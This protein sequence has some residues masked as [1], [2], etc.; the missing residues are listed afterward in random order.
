MQ[1]SNPSS[2][3]PARPIDRRAVVGRHDVVLTELD[4]AAPLTVGNGDFAV[5]V[6]VTGLQSLPGAYPV[7]PRE[8]SG[9][10]GTLLG[11]QSTWGWHS[12][13]E[14]ARYSWRDA[15]TAYDAPHGSVPYVD[16][17]GGHHDGESDRDRLLRGNPH[18]LDLGRIG[19]LL[20][21]K[22]LHDADVRTV[23]QQL[24]LL[25]GSIHSLVEI[26]GIPVEVETLCDPHCDL[27]A[28]RIRSAGLGNRLAV[29]LAF[30]YGS[31][32]WHN[33]QD[34]TAP[35]RHRTTCTP[36]GQGDWVLARELDATT[37]QA[38]LRADE[39]H[40]ERGQDGRP[41]D[42][43]GEHARPESGARLDAAG[44]HEFRLTA[45]GPVAEIVV[46]FSPGASA[47]TQPLPDVETVRRRSTA[48]W[49]T[50]WDSG[51]A[52]DLGDVDDPRAHELER[53]VVLSQYLTAVNCSGRMPP[54]ETGLV[55]N[56]W[57]GKSHLEM[58]WWHAAHF[59][60]WGRPE[61]LHRSM[62]WYRSILPRAR[63]MA[64]L[65]GYDGARWPKQVGPE[66]E[67]TPSGIGPFLIWQQPHPIYLA[68]LLRRAGGVPD[69]L[70]EL[71][72]IV[73]ETADFMASYPERTERGYELPSP[74][75]PAQE[76]Y[77]DVRRAVRNPAFELVYWHWALDVACAWNARL[78]VEVPRAWIEVR[79]GII[80]PVVRDGLYPAIEGDPWTIYED[81]PSMLC[82]LG[83]L[84]E[85]SRVDPHVMRATLQDVLARWDLGSTW[86][87][88]Y[89]VLAMTAA[90]LGMPDDAVDFL[91]TRTTKNQV[92]VNGHNRQSDS[93]PLYLPGNGGLLAAVALMAGGWDDGPQRPHPG[94]PPHWAV[95]A[96]GFV[97]AP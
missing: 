64:A 73:T 60:M 18:R 45:Q 11:T 12:M 30:S 75:I 77:A 28:L 93:L 71:H 56:S 38:R 4:P 57:R 7:A 47:P 83:V 50:F 32:D 63:E 85:T 17:Q 37:Y 46:E 16:L 35:E 82:A 44:D 19:F 20:D 49:R 39:P 74:L 78:G 13:P 95:R 25:T 21:G 65:Q 33:A 53:R 27:L 15:L 54:Q 34:W 23:R 58:H 40:D 76:S 26:A 66:G 2:T 6:D 72:E 89:P 14:A 3:G 1:P 97:P 94:F 96:E 81:H 86:G 67:E 5:T 92:L 88:D 79:D 29:G 24:S 9:P 10:P 8:S 69:V 80:A 87:W 70:T 42:T 48:H 36:V 59:P 43:G 51:A 22:P 61:L 84:P 31:Q 90:R 62:G 68:E 55:C 52:L 91:L 41:E